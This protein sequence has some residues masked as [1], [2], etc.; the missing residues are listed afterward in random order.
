MLYDTDCVKQED[1][2]WYKYDFSTTPSVK[3]YSVCSTSVVNEQ[4]NKINQSNINIKFILKVSKFYRL[5]VLSKIIKECVDSCKIFN[6][7]M[8]SKICLM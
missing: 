7:N 6:Y 8:K 2:C 1:N 5:N 3:K 4:I